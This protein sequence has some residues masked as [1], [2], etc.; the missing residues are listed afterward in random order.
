MSWLFNNEDEKFQN[1]KR[2]AQEFKEQWLNRKKKHVRDRGV[3]NEKDKDGT[4]EAR[5]KR[6]NSNGDQGLENESI[7]HKEVEGDVKID[8]YLEYEFKS[9]EEGR[10]HNEDNEALEGKRRKSKSVYFDSTDNPHMQFGMIFANT[11]KFKDALLRYLIKSKR[12]YK[13][14]KN[15]KFKV[16]VVC[17]YKNCKWLILCSIDANTRYCV[18]KKFGSMH[19]C[20]PIFRNSGVSYKLIAYHFVKKMEVMHLV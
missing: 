12:D 6:K 15:N 2:Q 10:F 11:N 16:R 4:N 20:N 5:V 14:A 8:E 1:I 17:K 3:G 7:G 19:T 18:V 13:L 9:D